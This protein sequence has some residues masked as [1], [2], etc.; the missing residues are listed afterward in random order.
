MTIQRVKSIHPAACSYL[1]EAAHLAARFLDLGEVI[2]YPTET[3]Y[4]LGSDCLSR[5]GNQEIR[6]LKGTAG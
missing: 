6:A 5:E 2:A 3:V 1:M 4:G